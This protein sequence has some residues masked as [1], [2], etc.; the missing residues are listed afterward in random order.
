MADDAILSYF[1]KGADFGSLNNS[2]LV[3]KYVI[4]DLYWQKFELPTYSLVGRFDDNT[5]E[6]QS[7]LSQAYLSEIASDHKLFLD[8]CFA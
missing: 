7:V 5:L 8:Q 1:G 4:A 2:V 3:H 6:E